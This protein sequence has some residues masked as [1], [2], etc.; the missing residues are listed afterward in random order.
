MAECLAGGPV[1]AELESNVVYRPS[2]HL[3]IP[4][5]EA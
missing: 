4:A 2:D 5:F 3:R 1:H